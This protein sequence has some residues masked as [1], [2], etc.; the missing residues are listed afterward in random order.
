MADSI[1]GFMGYNSLIG[2]TGSGLGNLIFERLNVDFSK[3]VQFCCSVVPSP[4]ICNTVVEPYNA[5]LGISDSMCLDL[6]LLVDNQALY[7]LCT[8]ELQ[9]EAPTYSNINRLIA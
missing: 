8:T 4:E 2:A 3:K 9:I 7:D 5:V 6:H 1:Q